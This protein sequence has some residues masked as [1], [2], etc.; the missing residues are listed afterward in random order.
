VLDVADDR[1]GVAA[2]V[3]TTLTI[4]AVRQGIYERTEPRLAVGCVERQEA[5]V[6]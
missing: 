3:G 2:F 5:G 6:T 4:P 1:A